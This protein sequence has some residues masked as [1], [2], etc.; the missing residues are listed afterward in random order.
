[1]LARASFFCGIFHIDHILKLF[2]SIRHTAFQD[3]QTGWQDE[4]VRWLGG[5]VTC[6]HQQGEINSWEPLIPENCG[7]FKFQ[8]SWSQIKSISSCR[9]RYPMLFSFPL[10][11]RD[12]QFSAS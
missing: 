6:H 2:I 9:L 1:M 10:F 7:I 3:V 11:Q 8:L 4:L 12:F 5:D